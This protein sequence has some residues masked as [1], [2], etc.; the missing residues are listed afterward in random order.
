V[1]RA[2]RGI[3]LTSKS[4]GEEAIGGRVLGQSYMGRG[5]PGDG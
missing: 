2:R 5:R 3:R 4:E 1:L